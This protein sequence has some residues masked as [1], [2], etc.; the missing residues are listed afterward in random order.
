MKRV[1]ISIIFMLIGCNNKH[2]GWV[3]DD[4]EQKQEVVPKLNTNLG[5]VQFTFDDGP[6]LAKT[7]KVLGILKQYNL[8]AT[9]FVEGINLN[10]SSEETQERRELLKRIANEG[11]IIG[12]HTYDHKDL[13]RLNPTMAAWEL[14]KTTELIKNTTGLN[15]EYVR[16]PYGK[17]C[18][19]LDKLLSTRKMV[20][21]YWQI[22]PRE[23]ER[24]PDTHQ[25][26]TAAQVLEGVMTQYNHL[27]NEQGIKH[28]IIILHDTKQIT[29]ELLPILLDTLSRQK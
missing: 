16:P 7:P 10:G 11:H 28:M 4:K 3:S 24:D 12:N 27:H 29:V 6:N 14:D 9:F 23:W 18:K 13:C 25:F 15:V 20:P 8:Q 26:K 5:G 2:L 21:V 22:D 1:L 19:M 17:K